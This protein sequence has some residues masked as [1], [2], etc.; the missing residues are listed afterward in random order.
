MKSTVDGDT[1]RFF[2]TA[3]FVKNDDSRLLISSKNR[4]AERGSGHVPLPRQVGV[5]LAA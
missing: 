5:S 2:S 3:P 4:P 1:Q